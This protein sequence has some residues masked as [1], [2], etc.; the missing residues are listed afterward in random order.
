MLSNFSV[1]TLFLLVTLLLPLAVSAQSVEKEAPFGLSWGMSY[2]QL[3]KLDVLLTEVSNTDGMLIYKT[4][5]LPKNLSEIDYYLLVVTKKRGLQKI[6]VIGETIGEDPSGR[7]GKEKY[8]YFVGIV[9][10]R[11]GE[12]ETVAE[13][14]GTRLYDEVD[15]FYQC[16]DYSGCGMW[17]SLWKN[18]GITAAVQIEGISRGEGYVTIQIEGPNWSKILGDR[19]QDKLQSDKDAF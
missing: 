14:F 16:L 2:D 13:H 15:E 6:S 1:K 3:D 10:D 9:S 18:K 4:T 11:Y 17:V 19:E 7:K 12:R 5:S 8:D